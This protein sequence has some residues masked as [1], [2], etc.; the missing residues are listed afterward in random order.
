[1]SSNSQVIWDLINISFVVGEERVFEVS[2]PSAEKYLFA[3]SLCL[4][5][6]FPSPTIPYKCDSFRVLWFCLSSI[7]INNLLLITCVEQPLYDI[8]YCCQEDLSFLR[9]LLFDFSG[10]LLESSYVDNFG[11]QHEVKG[12]S[13]AVPLESFS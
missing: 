10:V 4:R 13:R 3:S 5:I 2:I 1:M 12:I 6:C 9:G 7:I 11:A 8:V